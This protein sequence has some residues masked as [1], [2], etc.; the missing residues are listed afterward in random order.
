MS[1]DFYVDA[2]EFGDEVRHLD[3]SECETFRTG[4][5]YHVQRDSPTL[6]DWLHEARVPESVIEILLSNDRRPRFEELEDEDFLL[7]LRGVNLNEGEESD[8]MLSI[9]FL[10][11]RGSIISTRKYPSQAITDTRTLLM[12]GKGPEVL[13]E[14]IPEIIEHLFRPLDNFLEPTEDMIDEMEENDYED[15]AE[16]VSE[17]NK[18][19]L[20]IRR[21]LKPQRFALDDLIEADLEFF[22]PWDLK[23]RTS[24]DTI[25]RINETI[26]FFLEQLDVIQEYM[27]QVQNEKV[28]RNTYLLS[29][30]SATF[31]PISFFTSLLGVN[32]GGIPGAT[33][34]DAF[35]LLSIFMI[36]AVV[37]EVVI[38][39]WLKFF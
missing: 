12:R 14:L 8:E 25:V 1:M 27:T 11:Y 35:A 7:V 5:W 38:L 6:P 3:V 23:L 21:F 17:L 28:N 16:P 19:L 18:R 32:V 34:H 24:R 9:R 37:L 10:Y 26:D 29:I 20:K 15:A 13:S 31:L 4:C 33:D 22:E 36:L 30:I 2:W 39:K